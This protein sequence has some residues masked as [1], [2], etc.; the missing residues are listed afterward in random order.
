MTI[1]SSVVTGPGLRHLERQRSRSNRHHL[2][3]TG[4][5]AARGYSPPRAKGAI[6]PNA[7][8]QVPLRQQA[9]QKTRSNGGRKGCPLRSSSISIR[10]PAWRPRR[11]IGSKGP[12]GTR[13]HSPSRPFSVSVVFRASDLE[14][15]SP[16]AKRMLVARSNFCCASL[17]GSTKRPVQS[18]RGRKD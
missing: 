17:A 12:S 3:S 14:G 18:N 5:P 8:T 2:R 6:S 15:K 10:P 16:A 9:Q 4:H 13:R 7:P 1:L 11:H